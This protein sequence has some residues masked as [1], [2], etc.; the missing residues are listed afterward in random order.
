[1]PN[2]N[3][4]N[5]IDPEQPAYGERKVAGEMQKSAPLA[6]GRASAS[7]QNTPRRARNRTQRPQAAEAPVAALAPQASPQAAVQSFWQQAAEIPGVSPLVRDL[8]G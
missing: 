5:G 4:Y 1:M 3:G 7:A 8:L 6:G 2:P